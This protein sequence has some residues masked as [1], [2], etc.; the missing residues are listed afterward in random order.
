MQDPFTQRYFKVYENGERWKASPWKKGCWHEN[1]G[2]YVQLDVDAIEL[3]FVIEIKGILYMKQTCLKNKE[4]LVKCKGC[5]HK[6]A[7]WMK[8]THL[9]HMLD[10]V[11]KFE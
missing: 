4:C 2:K 6:E 7:I 8:P 11:A 1:D 9:D 10:M 5:N 3:K